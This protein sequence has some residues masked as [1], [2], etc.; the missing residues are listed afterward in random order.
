MSEWIDGITT[1]YAADV[2]IRAGLIQCGRIDHGLQPEVDANGKEFELEPILDEYGQH[3]RDTRTREPLMRK[4]DPTAGCCLACWAE[5]HDRNHVQCKLHGIQPRQAG[6]EGCPLCAG[7]SPGLSALEAR[8][9]LVAAEVPDSE[10]VR[11]EKEVRHQHGLP[12]PPGAEE[13]AAVADDALPDGEGPA[14]EAPGSGARG[15][16]PGLRAAP[17]GGK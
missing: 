10:L 15:G 12:V 16:G 1:D 6:V 9:R 7:G 3:K 4:K 5:E 14:P 11:L 17:P 2:E 8:D 13:G